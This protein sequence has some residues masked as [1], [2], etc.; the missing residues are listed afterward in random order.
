MRNIELSTEQSLSLSLN[1]LHVR[2]LSIQLPL[3]SIEVSMGEYKY[4]HGTVHTQRSEDS[5]QSC[6]TQGL[7]FDGGFSGPAGVLT[8]RISLCLPPPASHYRSPGLAEA[9]ATV[10]SSMT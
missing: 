10:T 4:T 1:K 6:W 8:P 9:H 3:H 7:L 2:E 5:F